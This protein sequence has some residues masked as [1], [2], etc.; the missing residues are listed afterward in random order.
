VLPKVFEDDSDPYLLDSDAIFTTRYVQQK[1][2]E[3]Q[4]GGDV[5]HPPSLQVELIHESNL[6]FI[7][8][9]LHFKKE[10]Y[11]IYCLKCGPAWHFLDQFTMDLGKPPLI[12]PLA[13]SGSVF[14]SDSL[15]KMITNL[16]KGP[17]LFNVAMLMLG[18]PEN[19]TQT[20]C[21]AVLMCVDAPAEVAGKTYAE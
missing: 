9:L 6:K 21:S 5:E 20:L 4:E 17:G 1:F 11:C 14:F 16:W 2:S 19:T 8:P 13:S 3:M 12:H 10:R 7:Q 18:I 15:L